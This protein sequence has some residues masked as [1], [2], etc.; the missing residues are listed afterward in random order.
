MLVASTPAQRG[1]RSLRLTDALRRLRARF[2]CP[3]WDGAEEWRAAPRVSGGGG[4]D[5]HYGIFRHDTDGVRESSAASTEF[6]MT[7]MD[8]ALPVLCPLSTCLFQQPAW[9]RRLPPVLGT[10]ASA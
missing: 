8:W 2:Q 9:L 10:N 3:R 7:C 6:M 5:I 1:G 4:H